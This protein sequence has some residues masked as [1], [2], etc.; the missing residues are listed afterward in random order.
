QVVETGI[1]QQPKV[2]GA[3]RLAALGD[4]E[5]TNLHTLA[6]L[7]PVLVADKP[8]SGDPSHLRDHFGIGDVQFVDGNARGQRPQLGQVAQR[9]V[10]EHDDSASE[11]KTLL[12][13]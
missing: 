11:S 5:L 4:D 12:A 6:R 9:S 1:V 2:E 13:V 7:Q 8:L 3:V 10:G